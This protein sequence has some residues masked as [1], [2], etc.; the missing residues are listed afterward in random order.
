[1]ARPLTRRARL[2]IGLALAL[3]ALLVLACQPQA[4]APVAHVPRWACP[5]PTPLPTRI[6]ESRPL[7]TTTPGIDPGTDDMYF[8]P[9][10]QEYGLPLRT[11]TPY[12][13]QGNAHYL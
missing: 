13:V 3:H 9:W 2:L 11:P 8:A 1:M 4:T 10:E 12:G 6:K 5:S 7:P